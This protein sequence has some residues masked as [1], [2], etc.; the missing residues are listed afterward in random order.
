M[1]I[2]IACDI[3]SYD[4][5]YV[6]TLADELIRQE[7]NV[8]CSVSEFWNNAN[9]YDLIHIQW[10]NLLVRKSD[11]GGEQLSKKIHEI[12]K[13]GIKIIVTLH[14]LLPHYC[15]DTNVL[16]AYK[17]VYEN[18]DCFIHLGET[19][20]KLLKE[21]IQNDVAEHYIIPHHTFDSLYNMNVSQDKARKILKIPS[22]V[23][24]LV[25]F[26][27]FRNDEERNLLLFICKALPKNIYYLMPGFN[28]E[29][30]FRKNIFKGIIAFIRRVKYGIVAK[31]YNIHMNYNFIPD[32]MVPYYIKAAD[33]MFIPRI[34]ILN[35]GSVSLGMLGGIPIV[36]PNV[37]NV[38]DELKRSGNYVFNIND[39]STLPHIVEN[40]LYNKSLGY[41][42]LEY[43]N[44]NLKTSVVA[45]QLIQ[46]YQKLA[47]NE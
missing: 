1:K 4:N 17:I 9:K 18:A 37:G 29:K 5:P 2:L 34:K 46:I 7:I 21:Q 15:T 10:P 26:G 41:K 20:V 19:S 30:I 42:N 13:Y 43:A 27:R 44:R 32:K 33:A 22:N 45:T 24:C 25:S 8:T 28:N 39:F 6:G 35:S 16:T 11:K 3:N 40:A 36:G 23:R 47:K 38:G 14:N 31:K 12:H